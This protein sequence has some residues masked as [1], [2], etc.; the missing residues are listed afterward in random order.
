MTPVNPNAEPPLTEPTPTTETEQL[1]SQIEET[2]GELG[3]TVEALA[4]K[5]DVKAQVTEKAEEKREEAKA[6]VDAKL[7]E[8][9]AKVDAKLEEAKAKVDAKFPEARAKVDAKF[10]VAKAKV[11]EIGSNTE[12]GQGKPAL[13]QARDR[14]WLVV[15]GAAATLLLIRALRRRR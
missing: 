4:H 3:E 9:R 5:T 10:A 13:Q 2:R 6:K 1:Q 12:G 7:D 11:D 8:A 14:P 15:A